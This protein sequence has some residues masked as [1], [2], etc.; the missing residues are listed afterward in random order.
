MRN[1]Q[2]LGFVRSHC[3]CPFK[4]QVGHPSSRLLVRN[5]YS[6]AFVADL[7]MILTIVCSKHF[8][9]N[10]CSVISTDFNKRK[11]ELVASDTLNHSSITVRLQKSVRN[12]LTFILISLIAPRL[13]DLT[14]AI[15]LFFFHETKRAIRIK[16]D[17]LDVQCV[18]VNC[19]IRI[20]NHLTVKIPQNHGTST[21]FQTD[22]T[23]NISP[24]LPI[25][26]G[27]HTVSPSRIRVLIGVNLCI[28]RSINL[29]THVI[30]SN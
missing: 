26:L 8:N 24:L 4:R 19:L 15:L 9:S 11:S 30:R 1:R 21:D 18:S 2:P 5:S 28:T 25:F 20:K 23:R 7:R 29:V 22:R 27:P 6:L 16:E 3:P 12:N 14:F 17:R 13:T 10:K